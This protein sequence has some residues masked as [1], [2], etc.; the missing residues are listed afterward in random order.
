MPIL[1]AKEYRDYYLQRGVPASVLFATAPDTIED[2][3]TRISYESRG[4]PKNISVDK[5][6][7]YIKNM[8]NLTKPYLCVLSGETNDTIAA[9]IALLVCARVINDNAG[10]KI[11][12]HTLTGAFKD[13]IRD[14]DVPAAEAASS[15]LLIISN[16]AKNST[17]VKIEK[18]RDLLELY[19]NKPRIVVLGGMN[20]MD[21]CQSILYTKPSCVLYS[22][23]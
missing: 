6:L 20:P 18:L 10:Q 8:R 4:L 1:I 16:V 15:H 14:E 19:S 7:E 22:G 21:F 5:Q 9:Q 17:N 3:L 13:K 12:W 23:R 2:H 11:Y